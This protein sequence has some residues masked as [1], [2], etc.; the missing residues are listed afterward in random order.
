MSLVPSFLVFPTGVYQALGLRLADQAERGPVVGVGVFLAQFDHGLLERKRFWKAL[1]QSLVEIDHEIL[2]AFIVDIPQAEKQRLNAGPEQSASET[3]YFI[4]GSD[5]VEA[6]GAAAEH[7]QFR[8]K[9]QLA[10]IVEAELR[11]AETNRREHGIVLAE[12]AV[13]RDVNDIARGPMSTQD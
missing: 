10:E 4:S 7:D 5:G 2:G 6:G 13:S 1:L 11:I 12:I 9:M 8:W 3:D